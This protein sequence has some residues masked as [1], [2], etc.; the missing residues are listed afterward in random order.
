MKSKNELIQIGYSNKAVNLIHSKENIGKIKDADVIFTD[1]EDCGDIITLYLKISGKKIIEASFESVGCIGLQ[2]AGTIITKIIKGL[3]LTEAGKIKF[4]DI[5]NYA[6]KVPPD[7][8][9][10]IHFAIKTLKKALA[11]Y[12]T[13]NKNQ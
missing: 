12:K 11:V 8:H 1:T 10:C 13:K 7:K 2:L 3:S 5:L 9:E 4:T 6:E